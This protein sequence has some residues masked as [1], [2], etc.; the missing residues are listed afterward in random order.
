VKRFLPLLM[1]A[2]CAAAVDPHARPTGKL[3]DPKTGAATE[4]ETESSTPPGSQMRWDLCGFP[5]HSMP[6]PPT[7]GGAP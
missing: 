7:D 2:A 1:L 4:P 3:L 6:W 5:E